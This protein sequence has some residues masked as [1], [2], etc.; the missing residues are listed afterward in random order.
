M[1]QIQ[2][3][4]VLMS[5]LFIASCDH[6]N[7]EK[8]DFSVEAQQ[9]LAMATDKNILQRSLND[10]AVRELKLWNKSILTV[11]PVLIFEDDT[12]KFSLS[13]ENTIHEVINIINSHDNITHIKVTSFNQN[14]NSKQAQTLAAI[15]WDYARLDDVMISYDNIVK[16]SNH[17]ASYISRIEITLE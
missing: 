7:I 3:I 8:A 11:Y 10:L 17:D 9:S 6:H 1:K 14:G 5:L 15:I 2:H 16:P 12:T 4:L 13:S